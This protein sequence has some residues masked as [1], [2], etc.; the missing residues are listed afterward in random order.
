MQKIAIIT[1]LLCGAIQCDAMESASTK[2]LAQ[3]DSTTQDVLGLNLVSNTLAIKPE[4]NISEVVVKAKQ[5]DISACNYLVKLSYEGFMS[6]EHLD[7][8]PNLLLNTK[9]LG[10]I[11]SLDESQIFF[12]LRYNP[13]N[14]L[15]ETTGQNLVSLLNNRDKNTDSFF[16]L[17][18]GTQYD[19]GNGVEKDLILSLTYYEKAAKN[20]N[21][22]AQCIIGAKNLSLD[23]E[24]SYRW[25]LAAGN[26]G[27][28]KAQ[29]NLGIMYQTGQAVDCDYN[30][31]LFWLEKSAEQ[32]YARAQ[33]ALGRLY[34]DYLTGKLDKKLF[35]ARISDEDATHLTEKWITKADDQG[36]KGSKEILTYLHIW[37]RCF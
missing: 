10:N 30:K 9:A 19:F 29:F 20:G 2:E 26:A 33:A 15:A 25:M 35:T 16:Q 23:R 34:F 37:L 12:I 28:P 27:Y 32:G 21:I 11:E 4:L 1:S 18:L 24:K 7:I 31:A 14:I 36:V 8:D 6:Y 17:C 13:Q 3:N 5:G 22:Q